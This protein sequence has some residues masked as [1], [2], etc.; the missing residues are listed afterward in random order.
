VAGF[1]DGVAVDAAAGS[2]ADFSCT[3]GAAGAACAGSVFTAGVTVFSSVTAE[4]PAEVTV[5][6]PAS[7]D[8]AETVPDDSIAGTLLVIS[9]ATAA[10]VFFTSA[11]AAAPAFFAFFTTAVDLFAAVFPYAF[12]LASPQLTAKVN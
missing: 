2:A 11:V 5:V 7:T 3:T 9:A 6:V 8:S 12:P 10:A 4:V 1:A